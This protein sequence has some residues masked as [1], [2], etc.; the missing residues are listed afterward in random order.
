MDN[1]SRLDTAISTP[2]DHI[3]SLVIA[4]GY[5][6]DMVTDDNII[7]AYNCNFASKDVAKAVTLLQAFIDA[8][9]G[10]IEPIVEY[11][12][13]LKTGVEEPVLSRLQGA[14]NRNGVTCYLDTLLFCLFARQNDFEPLLYSHFPTRPELDTLATLLRMYVNLMR[15]GNHITTDITKILISAIIKAG[16]EPTAATAQQDAS[17]LFNFITDTFSMPMLTLKLEIAHEGLDSKEDDHKF[18]KERMLL[19]NIPG[20]STDAPI[21]LEECMENYFQNSVHVFR[22]LE[23][24]RT[25]DSVGTG[26]SAHF[27]RKRQLSIQ[28]SSHE[29]PDSDANHEKYDSSELPASHT[30]GQRYTIAQPFESDPSSN[31]TGQRP[32]KSTY[33]RET[34]KGLLSY[35]M[36]LH[37]VVNDDKPKTKSNIIES[38]DP[39]DASSAASFAED[40]P[41]PSYDSG[42]TESDQLP[43]YSSL[44]NTRNLPL[45]EKS[46]LSTLPPN[47][48]WTPNKEFSLPAWMF[49]QIV[50]FYTN[51]K[52]SRTVADPQEIGDATESFV[53]TRPIVAIALKRSTW[54]SAGTSVLNNR[55]VMVPPVIKFPSFV[56]DNEE[57][58]GTPASEKYV[59]VLEGAIFHRGSS[60]ASGHFVAVARE[61]GEVRYADQVKKEAEE[62]GS[63][64]SVSL[65]RTSADLSTPLCSYVEVPDYDPAPPYSLSENQTFVSTPNL[66][67]FPAKESSPNFPGRWLFFDDMLPI[68]KQVT[69]VQFDQVFDKENPYL[70]FYRL[71]T[72]EEYVREQ[73]PE[74]SLYYCE[75]ESGTPS[76]ASSKVDISNPSSGA[77]VMM[78]DPDLL[79]SSSGKCSSS[80]SSS[81]GATSATTKSSSSL[82][83]NHYQATSERIPNGT[84]SIKSKLPI[85]SLSNMER[86][87]SAQKLQQSSVESSHL[88]SGVCTVSV[89]HIPLP[90]NIDNS[91]SSIAIS[92]PQL[93]QSE[94]LASNV[95]TKLKHFLDI[96]TLNSEH[97]RNTLVS[98]ESILGGEDSKVSKGS[99][100]KVMRS[101]SLKRYSAWAS[102]FKKSISRDTSPA[103]G[104][105]ESQ[106][107]YDN[108]KARKSSDMNVITKNFKESVHGGNN[109]LEAYN[110]DSKAVQTTNLVH[111]APVSPQQSQEGE[112]RA[113]QSPESNYEPAATQFPNPVSGTARSQRQS[114]DSVRFYG[115]NERSE[116]SLR[117]LHTFRR[118][119]GNH[120][121]LDEFST[122]PV[123]DN[124]WHRGHHR[125]SKSASLTAEDA[126][127]QKYRAEHCLLM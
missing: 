91:S 110:Y 20:T 106:D 12:T 78:N 117:S 31:S 62:L 1:P 36:S 4:N 74:S 89:K 105:V 64:V 107:D 81:V 58:S 3:R 35:D 54:D 9:S 47:N 29:P 124:N 125:F 42:F 15:R 59:L 19:V 28:V 44:N 70:L 127:A 43:P 102:S 83:L 51:P 92:E 98:E 49:L 13:I 41:F 76:E 33:T 32:T 118:S 119:K 80:S 100:N 109:D 66:E 77:L 114:E 45:P 2:I 88:D 96:P 72:V 8:A 10:K 50:P 46:T 87:N 93:S 116:K 63:K 122:K 94:P 23:R 48:L 52:N 30:L 22:Q 120:S 95:S 111:E 38:G 25:L 67:G 103:R 126:H 104:V 56:A 90:D 27:P 40:T 97:Q 75:H 57:G 16:W 73:G 101:K 5:Q 61:K 115:K 99:T 123:H 86:E 85:P 21:T 79:S 14:D 18:V 34:F 68:D 60:T 69:E 24:R 17:D 84:D 37:Q 112:P 26:P 11:M 55:K 65:T 53:G 108:T 82:Y 39:I 7:V 121:K 6:K 71:V 113:T